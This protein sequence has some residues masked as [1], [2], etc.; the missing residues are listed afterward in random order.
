MYINLVNVQ[1]ARNGGNGASRGRLTGVQGL[2][3][4]LRRGKLSFVDQAIG[5]FLDLCEE[6]G[7][8]IGGPSLQ[9]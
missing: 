5:N 8:S 7:G 1:I 2:R 6:L 4:A 3:A 9:N